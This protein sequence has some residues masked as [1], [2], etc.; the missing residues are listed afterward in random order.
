AQT[1]VCEGK[2]GP[3]LGKQIVF[4][5]GDEEY[6]SEE[7]LPQLARILA[8]RHGF[9]CTVLFAINPQDGTI[10]P[11][12]KTNLPGAEAL[13]SADAIV[14]LLRF[15]QW[16]D[17][18]MKHFVDAYLAGKPI[19]ALRTSTHAFSYPGDSSSPYARFS[20]NSKAWPGGFGKQ[21][22]GET[23]IS[24]H[25]EHRKEATR[26]IIEPGAGDDPILRGVTD[27]FGNTDVYTADPPPDA[28]ILV[29]GEVLSGMS[30]NSPPVTGGK[31]DPMQPIVWT[32]L[33]RNEAGLTNRILCTTMGA[34][35]DLRNEGLRR[36][37]VNGVY[38]AVGLDVPAQADVRIVGDFR[39]RMYGNDGFQK[40]VTPAS[41]TAP[42]AADLLEPQPRPAR[43]ALE[44]SAIPLKFIAH[45][46]IAF[47]GG[48]LAER[49]NRFGYFETLL[50]SRF[51]EQ[52]LVVRNF[53]RPA[54]EVGLRQRAND[55]TALDDPLFAFGP[56]TFFCFFGY[57]ESFA[58]AAGIEEFK[59]GYEKFLRDYAKTYAR[60][61]TGALPRFVLVSP[62]AFE[63]TG[64]PLYPDGKKEN[65]G[66]TLYAQAVAEVAKKHGLA[67]V[68]LFTP[69][70]KLFDDSAPEQFTIN[71][72]HL[73]QAGDRAV[74]QI[75][76]HALF[77]TP[78]PADLDSPQFERL[79]TA[80]N[81]KSWLHRQD[82]CMVNG[83]YVYGGRRTWDKETFPREF[84]KVRAM[85]EVR[86]HYVWA[87]AQNKEATTPDDSQTGE[88]FTPKTRFGLNTYSEPKEL[89]YFSP[90]ESIAAMKVPEGFEVTLFASER[91]FPE[92]AKPV[93]LNFDN[94]G[95]LWVSCMP[96]YPQWKPGDPP[97]D[98]HLLILED[99]QGVGKADKCTTFYDHLQCPVG[100]EFWH[101]GVLVADQPHILFLKDTNGDDKADVVEQWTD[102]WGSDDTHQ[103]V[104]A[105]QWTPGGHLLLL[106]GVNM[107][108]TVETPWG[109]FRNHNT[110]GVYVLDPRTLKIRHF[111][112]PGYG[113]PWCYVFD[114]WGQGI[115]GDGTTAQ[116]HWDSPLSGA[117]FSGRRGMKTVF[118]NQGMRPVVGSEWLYSRQFPD[119]V[120]GQFI[121]ACVINMN[122]LT[123]FEVHSDGSG[124]SGE[125]L[126]QT[127]K[128][129]KGGEKTTPF[130]FLV[131]T[132][133]NFRP[134]DPQ[135][136]PDG[137]L[138]FG[139]WCNAL[140]GHMQYSQRDP[141]R[142]HTRGRIYR[143]T[144]KGK[145]LL[146]PV[147]QF[148]KSPSE[149]LDQLKEYE[150]RTRY[151]ARRELFDRPDAEV[152]AAVKTWVASLDPSDPAYE[153][154]LLEA[155]WAQ[156][157]HHI[158]DVD[159]LKRVLR[160]KA[161]EARA[162]AT[163]VLAD[164]WDRIPNA[165]E[166]IKPQ[167]TDE[168]P[169]TRVE[170]LRAL[171]FVPTKESV[172]TALLAAKQP[173]DYWLAY[174]LRMTIGALEPMWRESL[175]EGTI[176]QN[177]PPGLK[178]LQD[179]VAEAGP[180][181][182]A[183]ATL[184]KLLAGGTTQA[185]RRVA[186]DTLAPMNGNPKKGMAIFKRICVACH[187]VSGVGVDYGPDLTTVGRR[188]I[189][190]DII[191][192]VIDPSAKVAPQYL[193]TVI[194]TKDGDS[195]SGF[196]VAEASDSVTLRIAG[197]KN[198]VI[199]KSDI[200]KRETVKVSSMPEGL[201]GG[202]S[203]G[204]FL[205]L[206]SYLYQLK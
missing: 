191:E 106:E 188:L 133:R 61:E 51:P 96:T 36:L 172:E 45:E 116:Q 120:Q 102:G 10:D 150:L 97:P 86:D 180:G 146:K 154:L 38:W 153:R 189:K 178:Q 185:S 24:H 73:N 2:S 78:N 171:S 127:V 6:R 5:T 137:A 130:D 11:N 197:G 176:A 95:R 144:Y 59:A 152:A 159:L 63:P 131:S 142:D 8:E 30:R 33:Y 182:A 17:A 136:G 147:T 21:V 76:D 204:E 117:Q 87:L 119:N 71:G 55:Y 7:G 168:F 141:N 13:D 183:A 37:L 68:D 175:A 139:D 140:I 169:R 143:M 19:I 195:Y 135:I 205:D 157:S 47:V 50:H 43:A 90:E 91:E 111:V 165:M 34:A 35:T 187:R 62:I 82:Y 122:G 67:F 72:C 29:R 194:E 193:T 16:P 15:R 1:F 100:F 77:Q 105:W 27:I 79:R 114:G 155:L 108:T 56:D 145:P 26:G 85:V 110:P 151:R 129:E 134:V 42:S 32:R 167:V 44:P 118:D 173:L 28:K 186:Y 98:D 162:G 177:N 149:L 3:G 103:S 179:W 104:N 123:R 156:Q 40:G 198:Q 12:M 113:N 80:V 181:E 107:S 84:V 52:E 166:L 192:S 41:L 25:G 160:A 23:W 164:E 83:W 53:G 81:N 70:H 203:S 69:T 184:K 196:A 75:L 64:D 124:Y 163:T 92:L 190:Q 206:M 200:G 93:Q 115:V 161:G 20:Y 101:G 65:A 58:G 201:A 48:S 18:Q 22:L 94:K 132:D 125:R 54:D 128:D 99:T 148:G 121:Y 88:L 14:M 158:V 9:K 126:T 46:R 138:Y 74:A 49:M 112:T 60:D 66:L 31:N 109:P 89:H 199:R 39:P 174:T 170:A 4:L 57:N 202:M